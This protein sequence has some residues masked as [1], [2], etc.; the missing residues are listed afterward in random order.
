MLNN[1]VVK[2]IAAR[3]NVSPALVVL[4]YAKNVLHQT[5][6]PRSRDRKHMEDSLLRLDS[7]E[8]DDEEIES[9]KA[10]DGKVPS[11]D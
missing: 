8:L 3:Y 1:D 5:I 9:L 2:T 4:N 7:F 11:K 6:I 10:L